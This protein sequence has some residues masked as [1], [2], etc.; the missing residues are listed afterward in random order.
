ML[1]FVIFQANL[2]D[3]LFQLGQLKF[4]IKLFIP[5]LKSSCMDTPKLVDVL[6]M[7]QLDDSI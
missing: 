4:F 7:L 3:I 6:K 1:H 5:F 2:W